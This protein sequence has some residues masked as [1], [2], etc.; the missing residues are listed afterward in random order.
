[1]ANTGHA[2][3]EQGAH[4]LRALITGITGFAGRTLA[5]LLLARGWTVAGTHGGR[6]KLPPALAPCEIAVDDLGDAD[7]LLARLRELRPDVVFHLA[8]RTG[9][10]FAELLQSHA[11][12]TATLLDAVRRLDAATTAVIPGSSAQFG[13]A[14]PP[15]GLI[16]EDTAYRPATLY[17]IA[18]TAE[19]MTAEHFH[20]TFGVR[21]IRTHTF[22]CFGPGQRAAFVPAAFAS[23]I[24]AIERGGVPAVLDVGNL[25]AMR[26]LTDIRDVA[27]AYLGLAARGRPGVVYNVCSGT[28]VSI[29]AI[30]EGLQAH[31]RVSFSIRRD[32]ARVQAIDVAAQRGDPSRIHAETGW[33]ARIPL[34]QTLSD[35]MEEWRANT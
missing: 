1:M 28:A 5:A 10:G 22:N 35:L 16:T 11:A 8:G 20:R 6:R 3:G 4:P 2:A 27:E 19:A 25:D 21:V 34:A 15:G 30:V 23:Q 7:R 24:A 33:R 13:Q 32:P 29:R 9:A 17:G 14:D 12:A 31:A 26:D 18:K